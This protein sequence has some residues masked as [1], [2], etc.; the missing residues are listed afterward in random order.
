MFPL[1]LGAFFPKIASFPTKGDMPVQG[2]G[3]ITLFRSKN[4][5]RG[6]KISVNNGTNLIFSFL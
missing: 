3:Q 2:D 6:G 1:F 5:T 4:I